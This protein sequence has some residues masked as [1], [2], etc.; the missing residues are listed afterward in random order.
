MEAEG[1]SDPYRV[2]TSKPEKASRWIPRPK[3]GDAS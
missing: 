1:L 2:L 3:G